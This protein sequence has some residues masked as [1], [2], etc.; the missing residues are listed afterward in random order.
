MDHRIGTSPPADEFAYN[1]LN[2]PITHGDIAE[3][4]T[5]KYPGYDNI[6]PEF[7]IH[8]SDIIT[9]Y[10]VLFFNQILDTGCFL[11]SLTVGIIIPIHKQGD[12]NNTNNY[13]GKLF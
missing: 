3:G 9:P 6:P 8:C 2:S 4:T 11:Q 13:R 1:I 7:F 10:L 5:G 12:I